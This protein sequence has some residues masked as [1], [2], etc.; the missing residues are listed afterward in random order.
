MLPMAKPIY[1]PEDKRYSDALSG[2]ANAFTE[3]YKQKKKKSFQKVA[4]MI[5]LGGIV[6]AKDLAS[7]SDEMGLPLED[8]T[9]IFKPL[10]QEEDEERKYKI[11]S[12]AAREFAFEKK[13]LTEKDRL[14]GVREENLA[15][16]QLIFDK[17]FAKY[18][19]SLSATAAKIPKPLTKEEAAEKAGR[20]ALYGEQVIELRRGRTEPL[21]TDPGAKAKAD[22]D[23]KTKEQREQQ[24]ERL[25]AVWKNLIALGL[26][27]TKKKITKIKIVKKGSRE[28]KALIATLEASDIPYDE[29]K[30]GKNKVKIMPRIYPKSGARTEPNKE[31]IPKKAMYDEKTN[32][33]TL[34]NGRKLRVGED[35]TVIINGKLVK[36]K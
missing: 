25:E 3:Y 9:G 5:E 8:L 36:I 7:W 28:Y 31:T 34:P 29:I 13:R 12:R 18:K 16:K 1:M 17:N 35:G 10:P 22:A 6:S 33:L 32:M 15:K 4:L 11:E 14:L 27:E 30:T 23:A 20:A 26:T 24:E 19:A 21:I 2:I